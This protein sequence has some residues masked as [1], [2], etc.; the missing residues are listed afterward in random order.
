MQWQQWQTSSSLSRIWSI[1]RCHFNDLERS[2]RSRHW[3]SISQ[4]RYEIQIVTMEHYGLTHALLKGVTSHDLEWLTE[5][6]NDVKHGAVSQRQLSFLLCLVGY[7]QPGVGALRNVFTLSVPVCI[8]CR[9]RFARRSL[10]QQM[11]QVDSSQLVRVTGVNTLP[12]NCRCG[13][14]VT[15][16]WKSLPFLT[17]SIHSHPEK[18]P[19]EYFCVLFLLNIQ[20][21]AT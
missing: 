1:E 10:A 2:L 13:D 20:V 4:K 8:P 7:A 12:K 18:N 11:V 5:I 15:D 16:Q 14:V 3:C 19:C 6:F 17:P 21:H 9:H